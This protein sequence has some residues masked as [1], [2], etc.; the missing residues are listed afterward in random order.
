LN[1]IFEV[2]QKIPQNFAT[3]SHFFN[4]ILIH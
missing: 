4:F 2:F 1:I 3:R